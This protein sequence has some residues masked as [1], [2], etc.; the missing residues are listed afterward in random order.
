MKKPLLVPVLSVLAIYLLVFACVALR[1]NGK[2][3]AWGS[4]ALIFLVVHR[5]FDQVQR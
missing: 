3:V 2:A 1:V 5:A 4:V